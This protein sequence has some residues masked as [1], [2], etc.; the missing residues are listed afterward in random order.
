MTVF[1]VPDVLCVVYCV[2]VCNTCSHYRV[3][4]LHVVA[5]SLCSCDNQVWLTLISFL[6]KRYHFVS[7]PLSSILDSIHDCNLIYIVRV[8]HMIAI[9]VMLND[10]TSKCCVFA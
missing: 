7:L 5:A 4:T 8:G 6:L 10:E 1:N 9:S 3:K 2:M